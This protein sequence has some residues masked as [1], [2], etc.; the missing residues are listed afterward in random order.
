MLKKISIIVGVPLVLVGVFLFDTVKDA[1][2]FREIEPHFAG[3]CSVVE[4]VVGA[5]DITIDQ[6]TGFSYI[7][8]HDRRAWGQ[9]RT[10]GGA[11]YLYRPGSLSTPLVMPH[12]MDDTLFPHGISLWKNPNGPDRLFVVN[13]PTAVIDERQETI[14]EV[15]I[16]DIVDGTL[17]HVRT[18]STDLPYGLNDVVAIDQ[19]Q[20]YASIDRGSLTPTGRM[21]ES[22]GRLKRGGIAYGDASGI[23]KIE[24]GLIFPNGL[25][26]TPDGQTLFVAETTGE[27]FLE[28]ARDTQTNALTLISETEIDSGLDNLEWDADGN[29]WIGSHPRAIDF[30]AHGKDAD[31]RSPSQVLKVSFNEEGLEVEEVY[32]NDGNPLSGSSVG[33]PYSNGFLIGAVFE[34]FILDCTTP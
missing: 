1:G 9:D 27:R 21:L 32:L 7:S 10:L 8:A 29:L 24:G 2:A 19:D 25:Q 5:E 26:L 31:A 18:V 13:H 16:F 11:I 22:Y 34:P 23:R 3:T 28:Y 15:V 33:A 14:S 30:P 4:G 12:T 6:S 20:F 17:E